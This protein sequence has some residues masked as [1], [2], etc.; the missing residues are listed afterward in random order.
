MLC[1]HCR[2]V[3]VPAQLHLQGLG[4]LEWIGAHSTNNLLISAIQGL[5]S[6]FSLLPCLRMEATITEIINVFVIASSTGG[7]GNSPIN[8][9]P[10]KSMPCPAT[11]WAVVVCPGIQKHGQLY[12]TKML[13]R[14]TEQYTFLGIFLLK[15]GVLGV[16]VNPALSRRE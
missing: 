3:G 7:E 14:E 8:I 6:V 11:H 1:G 12:H 5:D 10:L 15:K 4:S 16:Q 13:S 2:L 9:P